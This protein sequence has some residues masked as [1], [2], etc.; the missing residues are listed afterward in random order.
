[1]NPATYNLLEGIVRATIQ[2]GET[3]L[4]RNACDSLRSDLT[5]KLLSLKVVMRHE[6]EE[7][8]IQAMAQTVLALAKHTLGHPVKNSDGDVNKHDL[9][10]VARELESRSD[11]ASEQIDPRDEPCP[12][13][14][15]A[16]MYCTCDEHTP[17]AICGGTRRE[18]EEAEY[19]THRWVDPKNT[20]GKA[21][22]MSPG[23]VTLALYAEYDELGLDHRQW[24]LINDEAGN[25]SVALYFNGRKDSLSQEQVEQLEEAIRP[26]IEGWGR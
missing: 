21:P 8:L 10:G 7:S 19:S 22:E 1:M 15:E 9:L 18:H 20:A 11:Q 16:R 5:E 25:P 23:E 14:G 12:T 3:A 6:D 26:I 17:C 24:K 4:Q 13:C 2:I